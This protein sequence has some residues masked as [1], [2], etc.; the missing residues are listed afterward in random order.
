MTIVLKRT[1][2]TVTLKLTTPQKTAKLFIEDVSGNTICLREN[3][4][5]ITSSGTSDTDDLIDNYS[6]NI[7]YNVYKVITSLERVHDWTNNNNTNKIVPII[8]GY[9]PYICVCIVSN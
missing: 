9:A 6:F 2:R 5:I 3:Q 7:S 4:D 8:I 1:A